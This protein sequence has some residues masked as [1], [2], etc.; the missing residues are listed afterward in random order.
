MVHTTGGS[1]KTIFH[2]S[3]SPPSGDGYVYS[4]VWDFDSSPLLSDSG[5]SSRDSPRSSS[6]SSSMLREPVTSHTAACL[7]KFALPTGRP[8]RKYGQTC[9]NLHW[10]PSREQIA[11]ICAP[12][13]SIL[14]PYMVSFL[15]WQQLFIPD[16][17]IT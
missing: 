1:E 3:L 2:F 15:D 16:H 4:Q 9:K 7:R 10:R 5:R 11:K 13:K 12:P 6:S 8:R 14:A 17:L